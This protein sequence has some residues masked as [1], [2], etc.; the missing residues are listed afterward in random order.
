M[1]TNDVYKRID[2]YIMTYMNGG[3][4]AKPK[5]QRSIKIFSEDADWFNLISE[6]TRGDNA[7]LFHDMRVAY[8]EKHL[9][10]G[11]IFGFGKKEAK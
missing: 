5:R 3:S 7:D 8:E 6:D 9:K 2:L 11:G 4:M 1:L 10:K